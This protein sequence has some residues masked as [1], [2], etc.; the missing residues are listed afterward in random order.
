MKKALFFHFKCSEVLMNMIVVF[1]AALDSNATNVIN[2]QKNNNFNVPVVGYLRRMFVKKNHS[3][4]IQTGK[5][6]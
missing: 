6:Y 5:Q 2:C 1:M 3:F 4:Y